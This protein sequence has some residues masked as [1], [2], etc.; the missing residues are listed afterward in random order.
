M[1]KL[2]FFDRLYGQLEEV[3]LRKVEE[4]RRLAS[5]RNRERRKEYE[6]V[7]RCQLALYV[8]PFYEV[9]RVTQLVIKL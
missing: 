2:I 4:E 3:K 8:N 5:Q 1:Q 9:L 6:K 7:I